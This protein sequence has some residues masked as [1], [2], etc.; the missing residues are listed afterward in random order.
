MTTPEAMSW[1]GKAPKDMTMEELQSA[2]EHVQTTFD[3]AQAELGWKAQAN[4]WLASEIL[5]R[6]SMTSQPGYI[7]QQG[8][9]EYPLDRVA[10]EFGA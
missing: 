1:V 10:K 6:F 5:A 7:A 3:A 4:T 9:P 8:L 2:K